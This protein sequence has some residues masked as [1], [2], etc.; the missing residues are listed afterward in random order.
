MMPGAKKLTLEDAKN[1]KALIYKQK[2]EN[3]VNFNDGDAKQNAGIDNEQYIAFRLNL[4]K[5]PSGGESEKIHI[6]AKGIYNNMALE[7][8]LNSLKT[9]QYRLDY[10]WGK[11]D[12]KDT[13]VYIYVV[14][15]KV[16]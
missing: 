15:R 6:I 8:G 1:A 3:Q 5:K 16:S 13:T 12:D 9:N 14:L 4:L 11:T 7:V 10:A 2:S